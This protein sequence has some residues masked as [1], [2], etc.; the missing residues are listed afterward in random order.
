[1]SFPETVEDFLGAPVRRKVA[2]RFGGRLKALVSGGAP[3]NPDIALFFTALG[4][5][6]LQGYGQT[7][8]AP[9]QRQSAQQGKNSHGGSGD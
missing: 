7:E 5:R 3:L 9:R 8:S 2:E 1:M 4:I 6:I